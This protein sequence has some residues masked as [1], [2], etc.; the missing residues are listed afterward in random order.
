MAHEEGTTNIDR[1][2]NPMAFYCMMQKMADD[3]QKIGAK[4]INSKIDLHSHCIKNMNSISRSLNLLGQEKLTKEEKEELQKHIETFEKEAFPML[5]D[6]GIL[7]QH[8]NPIPEGFNTMTATEKQIFDL[9]TNLEELAAKE[10]RALKGCSDDLYQNSSNHHVNTLTATMGA[11][12][13]SEMDV[14]VRAQR[15]Q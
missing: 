13:Q 12:K 4:A 2:I 3:N 1:T 14:F 11:N 9:E 8:E 7:T 15:S 6:E 5:V 10:Q